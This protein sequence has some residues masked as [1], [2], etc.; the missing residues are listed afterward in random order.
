MIYIGARPLI[1]ADQVFQIG[2]CKT[3]LVLSGGGARA[4]AQIGVLKVLERAGVHVDCIAGTSTGAL[5]GALYATGMKPA[6]I[7]EK[8]TNIDWGS[9]LMTDLSRS[10]LYFRRKEDD[11]NS[12]VSYRLRFNGTNFSLPKS[13]INPHKLNLAL[14]NLLWQARNIADFN[15]LPIPFRA[16]SVDL[17]TGEEVVLKSGD[18][19]KSVLASMAVPG[20]LAPVKLGKHHLVDGGLRNNIPVSIA[21]NMGAEILI[22]IDT[23]TP[24]RQAED[25]TNFVSTT[26]QMINMQTQGNAIG[27]IASL[28]DNDIHIKPELE[29]ISTY[30]YS[31]FDR[32]IAIGESAA[33]NAI[34]RLEALSA[35]K[36]PVKEPLE[37]NMPSIEKIQLDNRTNLSNRVIRK[38]MDLNRG[39]ILDLS[40]LER[41][42]SSLYHLDAFDS[43]DYRVIE[44]RSAL[45][46]ITLSKPEGDDF[47]R[48][49]LNMTTSTEGGSKFNFLL[50]YTR[51]QINGYN[52]E[53]R[54]IL[55]L[56]ERHG[57]KSQYY[58][59]LEAGLN[60]FIAPAVS[61]SNN[62][63][64]IYFAGKAIDTKR[65][66]NAVFE[67]ALGS[68][69]G[70][71]GQLRAGI[72]KGFGKLPTKIGASTQDS[73]NQGG[74]AYF[75][76][77][78]IDT[79]D[80]LSFPHNGV[81]FD[82][83]WTHSSE[84]F[85]SEFDADTL[86]LKSIFA[87]TL[88]YNTFVAAFDAGATFSQDLPLEDNLRLGGFLNLSGFRQNGLS[89]QHKILAKLIY[90]LKV[91]GFTEGLLT[92]PVYVGCALETGNI[93]LIKDQ[94]DLESLIWGGTAFIGIETFLGPIY[95]GLGV[96]EG[97]SQVL[98]LT[99]GQVF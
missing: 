99:L 93:W 52:G 41:K 13:I 57:L 61:I 29:E 77:L 35:S 74:G 62:S 2:S 12:L 17:E 11:I 82:L 76:E 98:H 71:W 87:G 6:E 46:I 70:R 25:V 9:V 37:R 67:I 28:S 73:P 23:T 1:A 97:W 47:I 22:V 26:D 18:L 20:I 21:R 86:E 34:G 95:L 31:A 56:G 88:G 24:L 64:D 16:S 69:F 85:G 83:N 66:N 7:E 68:Q 50:N 30:D 79:L 59:P 91:S 92:F 33:L 60:Y 48:F 49:G 32:T 27:S 5:I 96:R 42:I 81:L 14:K 54:N 45:R 44:N 80:S 36:V 10:K 84:P 55:E 8:L 65:F 15:D 51:T 53:W 89:G 43:I 3:A 4:G 19:A 90:Y 58:Q 63:S 78:S 94:I 38:E 75:T 72:L 40:L 39:K